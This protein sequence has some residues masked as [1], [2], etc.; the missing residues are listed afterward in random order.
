VFLVAERPVQLVEP[1]KNAK[2]PEHGRATLTC[3]LSKPNKP[4]V[5]FKNG[6]ELTPSESPRYSAVN[7]DCEYTLT[8]DDCGLDDTAEYSMRCQDIETSATLTV[9]GKLLNTRKQSEP[10][11]LR[12]GNVFR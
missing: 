1:L 8:L 9:D 12:Q 10:A 6:V 2:A 3:K 11:H 4:V 7:E 5:W